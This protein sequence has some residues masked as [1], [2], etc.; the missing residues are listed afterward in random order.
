MAGKEIKTGCQMMNGSTHEKSSQISPYNITSNPKAN[1]MKLCTSERLDYWYN[2][3]LIQPVFLVY[4][5]VHHS[6][7]LSFKFKIDITKISTTTSAPSKNNLKKNL[8]PQIS[9]FGL[10]VVRNMGQ[11]LVLFHPSWS[12]K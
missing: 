5:W 8:S 9:E 6:M 10:F 1:Y 11:Q 2:F 7:G 3:T 12:L 4:L